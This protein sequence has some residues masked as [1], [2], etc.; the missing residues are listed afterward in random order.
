MSL[1]NRHS[2]ATRRIENS[3]INVTRLVTTEH[4]RNK[5][6]LRK[7]VALQANQTISSTNLF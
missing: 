7:S 1:R 3:I 5:Y 4:V 2:T 6:S